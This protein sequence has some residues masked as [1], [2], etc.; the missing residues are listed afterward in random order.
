MNDCVQQDCVINPRHAMTAESC[1]CFNVK[2]LWMG[3]ISLTYISN[4][5]STT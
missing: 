1:R 3:D 4:E 2:L 5:L